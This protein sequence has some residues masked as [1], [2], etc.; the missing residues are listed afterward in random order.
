MKKIQKLALR[1]ETL[2]LLTVDDLHRVAGGAEG[3]IVRPRPS[4]GCPQPSSP[5][6]NS[7]CV[8]D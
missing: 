4:I 7:A 8:V 2:R 1:T 5:S 3:I 6:H